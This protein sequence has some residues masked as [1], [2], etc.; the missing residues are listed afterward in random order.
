M[1]GELVVMQHLLDDLT[2]GSASLQEAFLA[3]SC[4]PDFLADHSHGGR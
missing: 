2:L 1:G 4:R 3:S